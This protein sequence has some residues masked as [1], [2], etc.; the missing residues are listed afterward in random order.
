MASGY[1]YQEAEI[2]VL[3]GFPCIARFHVSPAERDVGIM[4][5]YIDP[6]DIELLTLKGKPAHFIEAKVNWEDVVEAIRTAG[7]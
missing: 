6:H 4:G 7:Y 5:D 1:Y 3:G 2:T